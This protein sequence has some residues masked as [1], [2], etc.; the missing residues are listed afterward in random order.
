M[1][2]EILKLTPQLP[3]IKGKIFFV[4]VASAAKEFIFSRMI[5]QHLLEIWLTARKNM[6]GA[7]VTK[8]F[9]AYVIQL[10]RKSK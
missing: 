5:C 7:M 4:T 1:R 9:D 6:G 10:C 3:N 8:M 2:N